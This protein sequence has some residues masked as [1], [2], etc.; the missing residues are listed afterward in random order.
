M[1]VT[2]KKIDAGGHS[3]NILISGEGS[4]TVIFEAGSG[5]GLESWSAV[6][7]IT[8]EF[9]RTVSYDRAGIGQSEP[10]PK[11][12]TANQIAAELHTA[13]QRADIAPPYVLVGHSFGGIYAR[14][15]ADMYPQEVAGMVLIDPSQEAFVDWTK[16]HL[17]ADSGT[18]DEQMAKAPQGV[19]DE[20]A[21]ESA[22]YAQAR[23]AKV[24]ACIPVILLTAMKDDNMPAEVTE[25][26]V[27]KHEEWI[28]T[29]P[30]G[31]HILVKNSG[32]SIQN[33]QPQVV[34]DAIKEVID[35]LRCK[36][37]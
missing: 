11:P 14:V 2:S 33:E 31:K 34:L 17:E 10:G 32:H 5:A 35:R 19:R 4:P 20:L 36:T 29:V 22:S 30:G 28:A 12:R 15:F 26:W 1:K 27:D 16:T 7:S 37:Q 18:L 24:P 21:G 3:L 9:A 25:V 6:E 23:A 8:A 13:L